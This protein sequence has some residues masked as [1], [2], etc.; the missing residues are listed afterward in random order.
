[1][2]SVASMNGAP[3]MAPTPISWPGRSAAA[4]AGEQDRHERDHR[5]GQR[6]AHGGEDAADRALGQ[7]QLMAEPLDAVGEQL[8]RD[9]G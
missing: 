8:G 3:R 9:A 1:M 2:A 6:R 5:L 4:R 7:V